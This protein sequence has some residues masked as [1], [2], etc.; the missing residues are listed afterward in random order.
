LIVGGG[1]GV[2]GSIYAGSS[3]YVA[4]SAVATISYVTGQ[5]FLTTSSASSTYLTISNASSTYLT[6]TNA[7]STYQPIITASTGLTKSGNVLSVNAA[8]SSITSVGTLTS[9]SVNSSIQTNSFTTPTGQGCAIGWNRFGT[10]STCFANQLG[11]GSGG[12][13]FASFSNSNIITGVAAT[14]SQQG[15]VHCNTLA[16]NDPRLTLI[17]SNY[18]ATSS[19]AESGNYNF[20]FTP[21]TG[22]TYVQFFVQGCF[23]WNSGSSANQNQALH[24]WDNTRGQLI[25][26][27]FSI[28][29]DQSGITIPVTFSTWGQFVAGTTYSLTLYWWRNFVSGVGT[30][31]LLLTQNNNFVTIYAKEC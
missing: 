31:A 1:L 26:F 30:T 29:S 2:A 18:V 5:S 23:T 14:I 20:S 6:I 7:S 16:V 10:G 9:L 8:Q 13:E 17:V 19:A 21:R 24:L 28:R 4:G 11:S 25:G 15:D 3:I 27:P 12:W 22:T